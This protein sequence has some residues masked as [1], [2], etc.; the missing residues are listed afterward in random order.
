MLYV[1]FVSPRARL[2][3]DLASWWFKESASLA[4][5][6]SDFTPDLSFYDGGFSITPL[7]HPEVDLLV[8]CLTV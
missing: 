6:R 2:D 5:F 1:L 4:L 8:L 7:R 3:V